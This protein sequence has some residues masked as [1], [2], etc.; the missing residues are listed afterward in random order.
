MKFKF[1]I[2]LIL[3]CIL[4]INSQSTSKKIKVHKIWVSTIENSYNMNGYFYEAGNDYI[5][6][7]QNSLNDSFLDTLKID[8]TNIYKIKLRKKGAIGKGTWIG[9]L[10]GTFTGAVIGYT[11]TEEDED[12]TWGDF[13]KGV[14]ST[15]WGLT[16]LMVGTGVGVL[17]GSK[18]KK[19]DIN[20]RLTNYT[21]ILKELRQY[22]IKSFKP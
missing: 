17:V 16:G 12:K 2:S 20:K 18:S 13:S 15:A 5:K 1:T 10:T 3:L 8:I 4:Q 9:A 19:F 11:A 7:L 22:E 21:A 14:N 6:I